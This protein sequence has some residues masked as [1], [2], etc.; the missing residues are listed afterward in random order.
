MI[1][2]NFLFLLGQGGD[3]DPSF[4]LK[5]YSRL[6]VEDKT[7]PEKSVV[8]N[9]VEEYLDKSKT[10]NKSKLDAFLDDEREKFRVDVIGEGNQGFSDVMSEITYFK[11]TGTRGEI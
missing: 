8:I 9:E 5:E 2:T 7:I 10:L 1:K 4:I 11:K 6:F 3:C